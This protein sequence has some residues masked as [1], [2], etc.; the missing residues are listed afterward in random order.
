LL[1]KTAPRVR[2]SRY[3]FAEVYLALEDVDKALDYLRRSYQLRIPDM[4]GIGVDPLFQFLYGHPEFEQ[5][6][7]SLAVA[8][9]QQN[10]QGR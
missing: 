5:I 8:L 2:R 1:R 9:P 10:V 7:R 6:V 3:Y 4:I